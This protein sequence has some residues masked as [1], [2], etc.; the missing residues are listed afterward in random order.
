M[1]DLANRILWLE[2]QV[3]MLGNRL[4]LNEAN[5]ATAEQ[6]GAALWYNPFWEITPPPTSDF[7]TSGKIV[8][9]GPTGSAIGVPSCAV[10]F[11]DTSGAGGTTYATYTTDGSGNYSGPGIATIGSTTTMWIHL[12]PGDTFASRFAAFTPVSRP[13]NTGPNAIP[14]QS[15]S[16][17]S[18]YL[19]S[20]FA[21]F[22]ISNSLTI[23][24]SVLITGGVAFNRVG[25]QWLTPTS[26]YPLYN[27]PA[28]GS[29]TAQSN[30]GVIISMSG[31]ASAT[32]SISVKLNS[33]SGVC[34]QTGTTGGANY[35]TT[36]FTYCSL[37]STSPVTISG[38][39]TYS[40]NIIYC[41][42]SPTITIHE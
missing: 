41:S 9:C 3:I 14:S 25:S 4:T 26:P 5:H 17:A 16:P 19:C 34:P 31:G 32:T 33:F 21:Y 15:L 30:V 12:T 7:S 11:T 10:N 20:A 29:C 35:I 40:N 23:T 1:S 36:G 42:N 22:P 18:G 2:R 8:A 39:H 37:T 27:F 38:N 24:D 6:Q 13:I 28:C